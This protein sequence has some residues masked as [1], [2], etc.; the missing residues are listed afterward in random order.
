MTRDK[1]IHRNWTARV[2][3]TFARKQER[4]PPL[5]PADLFA[6]LRVA[7]SAHQTSM[8]YRS[9][10]A[11]SGMRLETRLT[12]RAELLALTAPGIARSHLAS[13]CFVLLRV[14]SVS[15]LDHRLGNFAGYEH[16][17]G[18]P[19][20]HNRCFDNSCLACLVNNRRSA[21]M[22]RND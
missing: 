9:P 13:H 3:S 16:S 5:S 19:S 18:T 20:A 15:L 1:I 22:F 14:A 11:K 21:L 7:F 12:D 4:N 6:T 17:R 2:D 8:R 10:F